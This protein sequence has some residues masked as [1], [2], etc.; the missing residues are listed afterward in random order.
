[1]SKFKFKKA[2]AAVMSTAI[3]TSGIS[4]G[5]VSTG[6]VSAAST[7]N[8]AEAMELS[9]Y[10]FDA[11]ACGT[12][13]DD[14]PLTWR[15]NCHTYDAEASLNNA[16]GLSSSSKSAVMAA[17][18]GSD[19][20]DVSGGYHDAGDHLKFSMTMGFA[21][22]SLGW[23]HFSYPDAFKETN[24]EAHLQY[25]MREM[26]DYFMKVTYLDSNNEVI[27][28]CYMVGDG[29]DHSV[30]SAPE[31]QTMNRPTY[32]ADASHPSA[33]ASGQ[34]S[35]AL[36]TASL[37]FKDSDPAYAAECLKYAKALNTFTAKYPSANYDGVGSYYASGSQKDDVAWADLWYN[38]AS[39]D[40]KL[41]ASY[42]PAYKITG[43]GVYNGNEYDCWRYTWDKVWSGYA[44]LLAE[45]GYD[46]NTYLNEI[47]YE[48]QNAGGLTTSRYNADG[49]GASRYN[50]ALQLLALKIADITNETSYADA[51]KYQMDFILGN[52]PSNK[53]FLI[54]SGESWPTKLHHR[55]ANVGSGSADDNS[56]CTYTIYG[57]LIGGPDSSGNYEDKKNSYSC[58]EPAL[59][60]N[61]AF[62]LAI[63]GLY[64]R[65]G[66]DTTTA[67]QIIKNASEIKDNYNFG[68]SVVPPETSTSTTT[69]TTSTTT[70]TTTTTTTSATESKPVTTT[71]IEEPVPTTTTTIE[72][73]TAAPTT[74]DTPTTV[75]GDADE[76]GELSINDAVII[77]SFVGN[78]SAYPMSPN[79]QDICDVYARGDG[80][81]NMDALSVQ[82]FLAQAI[83]KLPES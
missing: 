59:D 8:Y 26:C 35:S 52:N 11:N 19:K 53:S 18:G 81:S 76:D 38:I 58:T 1:M 79:A 36:S 32:W 45:V 31:T 7:P 43:N 41:S 65:Y 83:I 42:N 13:V 21:A 69:T 49:W 80:I 63:A 66:G 60:Y 50:C 75:W 17:N 30:W 72:T 54:G 56:D 44:A 22:T 55:A 77:M 46:Q 27:T 23:A 2:L 71:T 24:S 25:I 48:L 67:A 12:E 4:S 47:K 57:A 51:A 62:I 61:G 3:M 40:G 73:P 9:L 29:G 37:L 78:S 6:G 68:G 34:M 82:K 70:T 28:F 33:D 10:F 14:G 64:S 15:G 74:T 16:N 39:N 5:I 20:V